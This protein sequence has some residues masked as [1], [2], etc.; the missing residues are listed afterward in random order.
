MLS[1]IYSVSN[2][3]VQN[4]VPPRQERHD[5]QKG[6]QGQN[7]GA[8]QNQGPVSIS[9]ASTARMNF[10]NL[11]GP[12]GLTVNLTR[13]SLAI[14]KALD[15][16]PQRGETEAM[17][18]LRVAEAVLDL[19]PGP[20][21]ALE[22]QL[23]HILQGLPLQLVALALRNPGGAEAARIAAFFELS[24]Q[25]GDRVTQAVVASYIQNEVSDDEE[26]LMGLA[27][28]PRP[29]RPEIELRGV[30]I[31]PQQM[32][33]QL[34]HAAQTAAN[35]IGLA[36]PYVAYLV[37][38]LEIDPE[39]EKQRHRAAGQQQGEAGDEQEEDREDGTLSLN[40]GDTEE[41]DGDDS[42][43]DLAYSY[44]QRMSGGL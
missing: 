44:Y 5:H 26:F 37:D 2:T 35:R 18:A 9:S 21:M 41:A 15:I 39:E 3:T 1:P 40:E 4:R 31:T 34:S 16:V 19:N 36:L 10:L 12:D 22:R 6:G 7:P 33:A 25:K 27:R 20:R 30:T 38:D 42:G 28:P 32:E 29:A 23:S 14:G 17:Y 43:D 11:T 24:R 8:R 13:L